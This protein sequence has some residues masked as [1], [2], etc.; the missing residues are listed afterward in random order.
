MAA[1]TVSGYVVVLGG[2]QHAGVRSLVTRRF[3]SPAFMPFLLWFSLESTVF[4]KIGVSKDGYS[5]ND[6][7]S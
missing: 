7:Q 5:V 2:R 4:I 6:L 1:E 3:C